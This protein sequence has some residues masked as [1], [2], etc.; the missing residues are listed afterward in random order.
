MAMDK[1]D[2]K[3]DSR[4]G[5]I[6]QDPI[7]WMNGLVH[8]ET[9]EHLQG[10]RWSPVTGCTAD[11][12][13][14]S[15]CWARKLSVERMGV[16]P[17]FPPEVADTYAR[18]AP[19]LHPD[20]LSQPLHWRKPRV[21]LT[22]GMG[23]LFHEQINKHDIATI[24]GVM[25]QACQHLFIILTKRVQRALEWLQWGLYD[26]T[27]VWPLPNVWLG[28]SISN[29]AEADERIPL[30]LQVPAALHLV[31]VEPMLGPVD[32]MLDETVLFDT[33]DP[34]AVEGGTRA[35]ILRWVICGGETQSGAR[36]CD[37]AWVRDI[38]DQCIRAGV[39]FHFKGW[40]KHI[41][42]IVEHCMSEEQ[43]EKLCAGGYV[44]RRAE[45][46]PRRYYERMLDGRTW[47]QVAD[48]HGGGR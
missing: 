3:K 7:S 38:R 43:R 32:L 8:P 19:T 18:F 35:D 13:C 37:P 12:P 36:P 10:A 30:L 5:G 9:G 23:D 25:A 16:N 1:E 45:D 39:A 14:W 31:S 2:K 48:Q 29:Q 26:A 40:G 28:T 17:R 21:V 11:Y 4:Y 46:K 6:K 20:R 27:I 22:C 34:N 33:E 15:R 24:F 41:P 47:E 44:P 42:D